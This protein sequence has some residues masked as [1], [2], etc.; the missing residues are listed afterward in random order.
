[1][2][3]LTRAAPGRT[4]ARLDAAIILLIIVLSG[5]SL[6]IWF[7][8]RFPG[9]EDARAL[10]ITI[11]VAAI[12]IGAAVAIL[13]WIRWRDTGETVALYESSAFV[14]LTAVNALMIG[15]VIIG[16]EADFGLA[17]ST[18][19]EA[20]IYLW[21]VTRAAVAAILIIGAA[22]S[23]RR[24]SPPLPP[25]F[26]VLAPAGVLIASGLMLFAREPS[27][28]P[29]PGAEVFAPGGT[30]VFGVSPMSTAIVILQVAIF[31]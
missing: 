10:D 1:M 30:G 16:K 15:I 8:P 31:V 14:A 12:M 29:V 13:A 27:L 2:H 23:L 18:P 20:P 11:N 9:L 4:L 7:S 25:V 3:A 28:P 6:S 21:T 24:E 5:A 17:A 22:R 19:G 26:M